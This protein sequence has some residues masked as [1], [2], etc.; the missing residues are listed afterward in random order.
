MIFCVQTINWRYGNAI[1]IL[2]LE[3]QAMEPIYGM[4]PGTAYPPEVAADRK[5]PDKRVVFPA[6]LAP[7]IV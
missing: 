3:D 2:R 1:T 7:I 4:K 5:E 6:P